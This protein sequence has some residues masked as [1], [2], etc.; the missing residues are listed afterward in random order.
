MAQVVYTNT[1]VQ[2][3]LDDKPLA[4]A[5]GEGAVY[6]VIST[7]VYTNSC[8][9]I[10]HIPKRT[11]A[12]RNK[13]EFMI[14]N[15]PHILSSASYVICW[16]N[17]MIFDNYGNFLGFLM[18]LAFLGSENLY[19]LTRIKTSK[20]L[21]QQW[22][23]FDRSLQS[24]IEKRLKICV[25]IAIAV[26]SIHQS[27]QYTIVD[28]K[29]Q[30][31][32]ITNDGKI[33][34]TD[35][36]SFQIVNHG[37]VLFHSEVA[38]PEYAPPESIRINPS[39]SLVAQ[40]WDRFSLAVSFYEILFGIHPFAASCDGQYQSANTIS[41]KI[42]SGLFVH[43]SKKNYLTVIPTIHS[44][45]KY[46][47]VSLIQLFVNA[48]DEGHT[49][50]DAR[51]TAEQWGNAIYTELTTKKS[52]I[53]ANTISLP[54]QN[55]SPASSSLNKTLGYSNTSNYTKPY[56]QTTQKGRT[57]NNYTTFVVW[58]IIIIV[59][60]SFFLY[61]YNSK[62]NS[63]NAISPASTTNPS[64]TEII[65]R[66]G[67]ISSTKYANIRSGPSA[68]Y[69]IVSKKYR[70][71]SVYILEKDLSTNWYKV[72]FNDNGNTGYISN[73]LISFNVI[74]SNQQQTSSNES[75]SNIDEKQQVTNAT[76]STESTQ[77]NEQNNEVQGTHIYT[78]GRKYVGTLL[79]GIPNGKGKEYFQD[80]T[81]LIGSWKE[82]KR[83]GIFTC[84]KSDGSSEE[85]E[86]NNGR[87]TR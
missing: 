57:K 72:Q 40:S 22:S 20:H 32:L 29:P 30:N 10:Y 67:Y 28:Y 46:L 87:R 86:F 2:I 48:F 12:R 68:N 56:L 81:V 82:G 5:G 55:I 83:D 65:N 74:N 3:Y 24:G 11:L 50:N 34:I 53:K 27:C 79:N 23:K 69:N 73:K 16:P 35:V 59:F 15:K 58:S 25:N 14:K 18:S 7:G 64:Q 38:T 66:T 41:E 42:Q 77:K 31:I 61:Q 80:N 44:N 33:S 63:S 47:P 17:E 43:G 78:D 62:I 85:Q 26:H 4:A 52:G 54:Q 36:D 84:I 13:I 60:I 76:E 71:E 19:E 49:N 1:K 9:K 39:K 45:F 75:K 21:Q 51:P 37:V 8:V 6:R 70:G